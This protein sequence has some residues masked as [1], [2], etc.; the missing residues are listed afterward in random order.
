MTVW[1]ELYVAEWLLAAV[2][3]AGYAA[4][5]VTFARLCRLRHLRA[6]LRGLFFAGGLVVLS[7]L[8]GTE[9]PSSNH[10]LVI[11]LTFAAFAAMLCLTDSFT[12]P[13]GLRMALAA[14]L[15]LAWAYIGLPPPVH[16]FKLPFTP[17]VVQLTTLGWVA[18]WA[19]IV[20]FGSMF[21]RAGTV[22]TVV[23]SVASLASLTLLAVYGLRPD[24]VPP[25]TLQIGLGLLVLSLLLLPLERM[26]FTPTAS[27]GAYA[28]GAIV[29]W[30][31]ATCMLKN[32]ALLAILLPLLLIGMPLFAAIGPPFAA[33]RRMVSRP[34]HLHEAMTR[35]GYSPSQVALVEIA[36]TAYL[37]VLAL[38]LV[39]IVEW[40]W[41]IKAAISILWLAAGLVVGYMAV[42]LMKPAQRRAGEP[43][44]VRLFGLPIDALTM[45]QALEQARQFIRSG[46]PH[47]I[48]TCDA[49]ALVRA[50]E[51]EDFRRIVNQASLVT[52]DGAGVVLA[53]RLLGLPIDVRV[54]GCDM[55]Q[56]LCQVAAEEDQPVYF[57][58]AEPGVAEEAAENL[59]QR[60]PGLKVAGCQHG[61][62]KPEEEEQ[63]V[64]QIAAAKPAV[65]F[66]ALGQPRQEKFIAR[67]LQEIGA[68]VAIGIGGSLDVISGRKKRAPVWMQ[69][70]G[71]E[72]L[73]R[74]A[75]EP[76][77]LPR[78]AALPKVV[79]MAFAELLRGPKSSSHPAEEV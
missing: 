25:Q 19:W 51:D 46:Q 61:Y 75:R 71:L 33:R 37:C 10:H 66:V 59:R 22:S 31:T 15:L 63:V 39:A 7:L 5:L 65:L 21:A 44:R 1:A 52:A 17:R 70:M 34:I 24:L 41:A 78:L 26:L 49:S 45:D 77:R 68:C 64:R 30:A 20:L 50:Q 67:H 18:S 12:R 54:A 4:L 36:G 2:V 69:R 73:Y 6:D 9:L 42:R 76:W 57:L 27:A 56:G 79:F 38:L 74:V 28:V 11:A 32:T 40:H 47:Y 29:A 60:V 8:P 35:A 58:G 16:S 62:F 72:W 3:V 48:V 53:A 14:L 55:V 23:P 43:V 13:R